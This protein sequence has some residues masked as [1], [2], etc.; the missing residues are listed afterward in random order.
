MMSETQASDSHALVP[1]SVRR[2][3]PA[4][5]ALALTVPFAIMQLV[6]RRT[7]GEPFPFVLFGFM[8]AHAWLGALALVPPLLRLI[9][10][11][12]PRSL[13]QGDWG[14]L[15]LGMALL[16]IYAMVIADQMPCF[17]GVMNCD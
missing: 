1:S 14:R 16:I 15:A 8:L 5:L 6:N 9:T 17:V 3:V 2:L 4:A 11:G 13:T 7:Y 12:G 10:A